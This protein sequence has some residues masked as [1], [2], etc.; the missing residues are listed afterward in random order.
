MQVEFRE[1]IKLLFEKAAVGGKP[2]TFLFNDNQVFWLALRI[3][4]MRF[5]QHRVNLLTNAHVLTFLD[6]DS[7]GLPSSPAA[8]LFCR[9]RKR[10]S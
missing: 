6:S 10:V 1:D 8:I 4:A 7:G 5:P 3:R 9:S 2:V